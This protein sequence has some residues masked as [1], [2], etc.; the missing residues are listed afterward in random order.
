M[1]SFHILVLI[2]INCF[3]Q[4]INPKRDIFFVWVLHQSNET[5]FQR[6]HDDYHTSYKTNLLS[7]LFIIGTFLE[8]AYVNLLSTMF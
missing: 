6:A 7:L 8:T 4:L 5:I 1:Q 2:K 3:Y